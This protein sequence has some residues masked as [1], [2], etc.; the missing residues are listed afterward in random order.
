MTLRRK[1]RQFALQMLYQWEMTGRKPPR[2]EENFWRTAKAADSTRVFA[3]QLYR[4]AAMKS[5][6]SDALLQKFSTNWPLERMAI[7]DRCILR[8]AIWELR[9]GT[10]PP[11]V[12][13]NE[14]VELAK[15][16]SGEDSAA[17]VNGILDAIVK[18]EAVVK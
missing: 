2:I 15:M 3:N 17:F 10:A 9:S 12:V 11:A 13:L 8:L 16:F 7:T 14:A 6:E 4:G 1:S 18:S 5:A